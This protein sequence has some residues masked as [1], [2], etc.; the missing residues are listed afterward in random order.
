MFNSNAK[1]KKK[2][3]FSVPKE[4][5]SVIQSRPHAVQR[6]SPKKTTQSTAYRQHGQ[7]WPGTNGES[8][9]GDKSTGLM[10]LPPE[11]E[12]MALHGA[13]SQPSP[14]DYIPQPR[15]LCGVERVFSWHQLKN[16]WFR[17]VA[18]IPPTENDGM[19]PQGGAGAGGRGS[20]FREL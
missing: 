20:N 3:A 13:C 1:K 14:N 19:L 7:G 16:I 8:P 11:R 17:L 12:A 5:A 6:P 18:A 2:K 9:E 15:F 4:T 10:D